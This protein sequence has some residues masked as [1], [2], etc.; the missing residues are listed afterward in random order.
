MFFFEIGLCKRVSRYTFVNFLVF[1]C[2]NIDITR[3]QFDMNNTDK[4]SDQIQSS[5]AVYQK[6]LK[7]TI[8]DLRKIVLPK[9]HCHVFLEIV[10]MGYDQEYL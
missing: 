5:Q 8:M 6:V 9:K 1:H 10:M 4:S 3:I 2:M 7:V